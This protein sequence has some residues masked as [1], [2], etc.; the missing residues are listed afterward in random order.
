LDL[1]IPIHQGC[2]YLRPLESTQEE[3]I[4]SVILEEVHF[5]HDRRSLATW[6]VPNIELDSVSKC[7]C[8]F[9]QTFYPIG[10]VI[11]MPSTF[12]SEKGAHCLY[13]W[14]RITSNEEPYVDTGNIVRLDVKNILTLFK[15]AL[16]KCKVSPDSLVV[17]ESSTIQRP[18]NIVLPSDW[19][20]PILD[21][22]K[23]FG[24][25]V[26]SLRGVNGSG[27]T[28]SALLLSTLASFSFHRPMF[29]LDCKILQKEK[30]RMSEI[31]DEIDL[32]FERAVEVP[33]SIIVLDD[34]D[35][36]SPNLTGDNEYETS[37]RT[38]NLN[39]SAVNQSKLIGD[40]LSHLL[41]AAEFRGAK[42]EDGNILLIITCLSKESISHLSLNSLQAPLIHI[43]VPLL[44]LQDRSDL[45]IE[46]LSRHNPMRRFDL[47]GVDISRRTEGFLPRDFEKLSARALRSHQ[48]NSS[49]TSLQDSLVA[50]LADFTPMSQM[51]NRQDEAQFHTS[52]A[53]VG[54]L[55]HVKDVLESV[56]RHPLLYRRIY[57]RARMKLPRGILLYG[58]SGCGKSFLVP[59]LARE[60]NYPLITC[61]GPEVLDKYIGASEAK[62][63]E[64]F[65]RASQMAPSILFLDELEALAPRRGSD[66]TGVTDRVV[67]QLLT[68]LDGVEDAS[69]DTV[70]IIGATSRPDKVDPAIIRPGRLEQH[71]YIGPPQT[72]N[73]WSDLLIKTAKN[74]KL[75]ADSFHS[76][77]VGKEIVS[78]VMDISR[79]CPADV[80]AAFD[81]A[82]LNAVHRK[83]NGVVLGR[84]IKEIELDRDDIE[85][86]LR[87]TSPS[88]CESE[89]RVL[90]S[91]YD[92]FRG[93]R[94]Q[95]DEYADPK[96]ATHEMKTSLR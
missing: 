43:K 67:N 2:I 55:F 60:C 23:Y 30:P 37:E 73:E 4:E 92:S 57:A 29:Y 12:D 27:K 94:S 40:R 9:D 68:F 6:N 35:S 70:F 13:R 71:L 28:F 31:L 95:P 72:E 63:R 78:T 11:P 41:K 81:T 39:P 50:E 69:S 17:P 16:R 24:S 7:Y 75:N 47:D 84:D 15:E 85:F 3:R 76:L 79:L 87:E 19:T 33:N 89:A 86:G 21:R 32:L 96:V 44:S 26:L 10:A 51:S 66:S 82:H 83:L 8:K 90:N 54:G 14:F 25:M 20:K 74:W 36:I 65:E 59:A 93:N 45:L 34:L 77:S 1:Q 88:L 46:M 22:M 56:V 5:E 53:D 52:W 80:R 61:K 62:V 18:L 49:T 38:H 48:T 64:L 58:P 91:I 42:S